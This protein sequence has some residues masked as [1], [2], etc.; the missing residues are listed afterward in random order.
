VEALADNPSLIGTEIKPLALEPSAR[1]GIGFTLRQPHGIVG[2]LTPVVFPL[3]FPVIQVCYALAAANSVLLKPAQATPLLALRLVE[4]LIAAGLPPS[5]I[6]CL[7]GTGKE[8][9]KA[10]CGDRRLNYLSCMGRIRTVREIRNLAAF[11]P[12]HLQWG[13][14]SSVIVDHKTDLDQFLRIF[15]HAAF[16]NAGQSAFTS[17]WIAAVDSIHDELLSRLETEISKI[18]VGDPLDPTTELGPVASVMSMKRFDQVIE[19]ELGLGA[20][21]VCGGTREGRLIQPT[22]LRNCDIGKSSL[23]Q[24]ETSAPIVGISRVKT[25][26]EAIDYLKHQRYHILSIFTESKAEAVKQAMHLPFENIYLNGI[27]NWRDGL[28]C[29]PGHPPRSGLRNSYD[30][31]GDF[32]R[33]RDVVCRES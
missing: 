2:I 26:M 22:L 6:A 31:V 16:D 28:V 3:L 25:P 19:S 27:P 5:A 12:T 14:V 9:G 10:I 8:I 7:P 32:S 29:V 20:E 1:G 13:C 4:M 24:R 18:K 11:V 23:G 21:I 30:R 15:L 33:L 17:S